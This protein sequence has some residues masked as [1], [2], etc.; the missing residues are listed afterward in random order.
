MFDQSKK[1]MT[2]S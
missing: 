2:W 1:K